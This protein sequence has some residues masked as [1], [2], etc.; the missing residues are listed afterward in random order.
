MSVR[1]CGLT[2]ERSLKAHGY[3]GSQR[4]NCHPCINRAGRLSCGMQLSSAITIGLTRLVVDQMS[5]FRA[6]ASALPTL[7]VALVAERVARP[8]VDIGRSGTALLS[9]ATRLGNVGHAAN[10]SLN[11][12]SGRCASLWRSRAKL[13]LLAVIEA[14]VQLLSSATREP[15]VRQINATNQERLRLHAIQQQRWGQPEV[16]T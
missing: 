5:N 10:W 7:K 9:S 15:Y 4:K 11:M 12:G 14:T 16:R 2:V 3:E 6:I 13:A 8:L 1:L